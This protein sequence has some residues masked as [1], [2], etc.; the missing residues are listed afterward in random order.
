M[1]EE[2]L[3]AGALLVQSPA[4]RLTGQF[5]YQVGV[6]FANC[7]VWHSPTALSGLKPRISSDTVYWAK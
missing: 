1:N 4:L 7:S 5:L 3:A 6:R 2:L